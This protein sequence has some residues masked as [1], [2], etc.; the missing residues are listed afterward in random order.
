MWQV[1]FLFIK[2]MIDIRPFVMQRMSSWPYDNP[3]SLNPLLS[4]TTLMGTIGKH[5]KR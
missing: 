1:H 4:K 3:E 2:E 5:S